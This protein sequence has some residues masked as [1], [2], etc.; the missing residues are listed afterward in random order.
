MNHWKKGRRQDG[1]GQK[2]KHQLTSLSPFKEVQVLK[3]PVIAQTG[4]LCDN[5]T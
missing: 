4:L 1:D 3:A 5:H 2:K